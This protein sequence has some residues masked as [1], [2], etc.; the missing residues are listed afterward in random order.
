MFNTLD[1]Q[2]IQYARYH[3][4]HRNILTHFAGIPLIVF[5]VLTLTSLPQWQIVL[6]GIGGT[7][8]TPAF[9]IWV[10]ANLYYLKLNVFLGF[11]MVLFTAI[12]L[13]GGQYVAGLS[14]VIWL[15]T[16][17][18]TFIFGWVLQFIGHYYEGKKPAF[19]DDLTGLVIGPLFIMA[20][21]CFALGFAKD[22]QSRIDAQAGTVKYQS[23]ST[24]T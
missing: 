8:F 1:Q 3:R 7:V 9:V 12:L 6:P 5:A 17:I 2:L 10:A 23:K 21:W 14:T 24:R 11:A 19:I 18:G 20:E 4:D 16:G 22:L 13:L 15:S